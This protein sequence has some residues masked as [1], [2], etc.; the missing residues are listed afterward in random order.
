MNIAS[1]TSLNILVT[2]GAGYIGSVVTEQLIGEGHRV[3]VYDSLVKGHSQ[4]VPSRAQF[5]QGDVGDSASVAVALEK[6][7]I[8]AV[9]HFAAFIE[10][11]ESMKKPEKYFTNNSAN[12]LTFLN[13]LIKTGVKKIIFSSTAAVY[14][15]PVRIPITEESP[16]VPTNAYGASKLITE[17]I[18]SW[19]HTIHGLSYAALRY[20][21]ACGATEKHG[22]DHQP[23]THL[24]P[25]TLQAAMLGKPVLKLF[26]TDYE[27]RDGTCI[28]DYIHVSD[29]ANAHVLALQA[30][31]ENAPKKLIYNLGSQNGFTNLEVIRAVEK[32][33]GK[34]VPYVNAPRRAGDPAILIASSEKIRK[35]LGWKPRFTKLEEIIETAYKWRLNHLE[36]YNT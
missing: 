13:T 25:L 27:T 12:T 16:L 22:E 14:G 29:L 23:E 24:I 2:G 7:D 34:K 3:V 21:N 18:L 20:F 11:G 15:E 6:Y 32:V 36:G 1:K 5:V 19:Y 35:E 30:L 8:G 4:A 10:A 26:G 9:L 33:A 28:R 31:L 17:Q